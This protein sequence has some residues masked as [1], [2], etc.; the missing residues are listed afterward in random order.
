MLENAHIRHRGGVTLKLQGKPGSTA[1][2][3][4]SLDPE[5]RSANRDTDRQLVYYYYQIV[6]GQQPPVD[7]RARKAMKGLVEVCYISRSVR[8]VIK[9]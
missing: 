8:S 4:L 5:G 3:P 6:S 2:T 9:V 1:G 7:A